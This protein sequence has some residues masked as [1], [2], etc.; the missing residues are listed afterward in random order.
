MLPDPLAATTIPAQ[1]ELWCAYPGDLFAEPVAAACVD[2]LTLE[3]RER[4]QKLRFEPNRLEFLASRALVRTAFSRHHPLPP[5]AWRFRANAYGKPEAEPAC[6]LRF[7][8]SNTPGLVVCLLARDVEVGVDAEPAA[9][10]AEI[11]AL[12]PNVFSPLELAQLES[13]PV[14][15]RSDRALSLWTLKEAYIKA[16]GLGLSLPLASFSF[17]FGGNQRVQLEVDPPVRDEPSRWR[18]SLLDFAGYRIAMMAAVPATP[19]LALWEARL[20]RAPPS[21]LSIPPEPWFPRSP[22]SRSPVS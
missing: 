1:L 11:L 22:V 21:R 12:A 18:F 14:S 15:E 8:L 19:V 5:A 10:A 17:L 3:E 4:W 13:L 20:F 16:R 2:L 7:N 9:R 6:G